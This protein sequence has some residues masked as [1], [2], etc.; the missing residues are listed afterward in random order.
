MR[1]VHDK[2]LPATAERAEI[3]HIPVQTDEAQQALHEPVVCRNA[4]PNRPGALPVQG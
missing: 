2:G 3:R 1:D 4:M